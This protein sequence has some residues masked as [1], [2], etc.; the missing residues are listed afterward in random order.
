ME[1]PENKLV[2][3]HQYKNRKDHAWWI[4]QEIH[5]TYLEG[6]VMAVKRLGIGKAK[7]VSY[8]IISFINIQLRNV[9]HVL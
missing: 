6:I 8:D 4:V 9:H 1:H 2:Q 5:V 3:K 7:Q